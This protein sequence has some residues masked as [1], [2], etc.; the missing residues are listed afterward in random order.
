MC[1]CESARARKKKVTNAAGSNLPA[2]RPGGRPV[3]HPLSG[4]ENHTFPKKVLNR[5]PGPQ[6][7]P[8]ALWDRLNELVRWRT[9][10]L[11]TE[12]EFA[13]AKARLGL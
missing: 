7:D 2:S 12:A 5:I 3:G 11:L 8:G 1:V 9:A 13:S 4:H 10:G 6:D